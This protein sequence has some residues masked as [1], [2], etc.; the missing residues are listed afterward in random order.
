MKI[1]LPCNVEYI[2]NKLM[3]NGYEAYIVGGCVRD[4]ILNKDP[5]DFDI[6]TNAKPGEVKELFKRTID[7][8]ILHGTV[9]V[10]IKD[11]GYEITTYRIDGEY[12]DNRRPKSV[13]FTS[14][15]LE[16]LRRRDF[17]INAM[18]YNE[19]EGLIDSFQGLDDLKSGVIRC[20][21]DGRLRIQED[22]LRILRGIRFSAQLGFEIE[23]KT[24]EAMKQN[25]SLLK[26]ISAERKRVEL[27][28]LLTSDNPHKLIDAYD[29]GI[30]NV[31]FPEFNQ[32]MET[33][34]E[35]PHH[36]YNVGVHSLK[37]VKYIRKDTLLEESIAA[38]DKK[39]KYYHILRWCMLLHDVGKIE[40]KTKGEDGYDHFYGHEIKGAILGKEI[41]KRL[42]FDNETIDTVTKLI[43]W[44][45]DDL[46]QTPKAMRKQ[47]NKMGIRIMRLYFEVKRTDILAG[48]PD[49]HGEK[50]ETLESSYKLYEEVIE[51]GEC[52]NL[53]MLAVNGNDLVA[54]GYNPGTILGD[55]LNALLQKVLEQPSLNDKNTLLTLAKDMKP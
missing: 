19:K 30:T 2:I 21:G 53:K 4:A 27:D 31:I 6:T 36:I 9:T 8:G 34:Q 32:M 20:V 49:T 48:A 18:A 43:K 47:I 28:K 1:K 15:L 45:E 13:E 46:P 51:R 12:E 44:H 10:M 33:D 35:N 25:A 29:L 24:K 37:A 50:L 22:A 11:Q 14:S 5:Q 38:C 16:D 7:T 40:T 17:T 52:V 41:L 23:S 42:K 26:N 3:E 39:E 55:T 54:L